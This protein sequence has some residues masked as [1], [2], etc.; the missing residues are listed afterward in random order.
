MEGAVLDTAFS[1]SYQDQVLRFLFPLFPRPTTG[2]GDGSPHVHALT[3]LLV[4]LSD[5]SLSISLLDS[6]QFQPQPQLRPQPQFQ[7]PQQP[8]PT[9]ITILPSPSQVP[10][11]GISHAAL[12]V[13]TD[14]PLQ[15]PNLFILNNHNAHL[16]ISLHIHKSLCQTVVL[17]AGLLRVLTG[18]IRAVTVR[19]LFHTNL[20]PIPH[21]CVSIRSLRLGAL[22]CI[23]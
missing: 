20:L 12:G 23:C 3:R 7:P 8:A 4:T 5:P 18:D 1:L 16:H 9:T 13:N 17:Q 11:G 19:Q 6:P 15:R 22:G 10:S 14:G 21:R 2:T